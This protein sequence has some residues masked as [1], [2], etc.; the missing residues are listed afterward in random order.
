[1]PVRPASEDPTTNSFCLTHTITH[2]V[3]AQSLF[4]A[5]LQI[6]NLG[7]KISYLTGPLI[8]NHRDLSSVVISDLLKARGFD[9]LKH[10]FCVTQS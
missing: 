7:Q 5:V 2:F 3:F 9:L 6:L 4:P 1:M 8:E 10:D